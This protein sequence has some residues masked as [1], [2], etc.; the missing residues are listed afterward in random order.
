MCLYLFYTCRFIRKRP[1]CRYQIIYM[2]SIA[3]YLTSFTSLRFAFLVSCFTSMVIYQHTVSQLVTRTGIQLPV[4][5]Q[6]TYPITQS[7]AMSSVI[8][9]SSSQ[10]VR[11]SSSK[12]HVKHTLLIPIYLLVQSL[13]H[14]YHHTYTTPHY[15]TLHYTS[16]TTI[17]ASAV[18]S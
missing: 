15:T 12:I 18:G 3:A 6:T 4:R 16:C 14:H 1:Q 9:S 5:Q 11:Q 8:I 2:S 13:T 7:L 17:T 10:S